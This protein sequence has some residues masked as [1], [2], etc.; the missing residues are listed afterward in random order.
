MSFKRSSR[1]QGETLMV[2]HANAESETLSCVGLR[3]GVYYILST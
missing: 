1:A 3:S 2:L